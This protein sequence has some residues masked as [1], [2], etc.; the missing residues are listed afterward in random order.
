MSLGRERWLGLLLRVQPRSLRRA[1]GTEWMDTA[2]ARDAEAAA[3]GIRR[4]VA[5]RAREGAGALAAGVKGRLT[6]GRGAEESIKREGTMGT[7][8]LDLRYAVRS[9]RRAKG[10]T[11]V[12]VL[13]L[14][15]GIAAATTIFS[16]VHAVLLA[17]LPFAEPERLV[18]LWER[19]PDFGWDQQDAAPAN[20][21]DWRERVSA[22]DDVAAYR[23][24][25]VGRVTWLGGGEPRSVAFVDVT[26]NLFDVLGVRPVL[27]ALP[28]FDDT[29]A[30][31]EPWA[32]VSHAFWTEAL[33]GDPD[34]VGRTLEL[35]G[36]APRIRAVLPEGFRFPASEIDL[37]GPYGW[38]PDASDQ[39]WFRRA[40]FVTPVARLAP[41]ATVERA[42]AELDAV[43]LELQTEHP[44]LNRNMFAGLTPLRPWLAGDLAGPLRALMAAVTILL[45]LACVNVG[46]LFMARAAARSG[47]LSMRRAIGAG[48][49]RIV[50]Q[51]M[52]ESLLVAAGGGLIG[53]ALSAG[54]IR[55]LERIRPLG[56]AGTTSIELNTAVL[57]FALL[58][59]LVAA[60]T[61]G[62]VPAFRAARGADP[63]HLSG[64]RGQAGS[65]AS[66]LHRPGSLLIPAQTALAVI[67]LLGAGLVTRSFTRTLAEEPGM[68]P[69]GVWTFTL[70]APGNRYENRD[71]MLSFWDRVVTSLEAAPEVTRAAVTGGVPLTR[72]GWTSQLVVRDWEP[73]RLA[74]EVRHR[75]ATPGYF[76]V[77]GVPLLAG[78]GF[79]SDD[80]LEGERVAIVN[81]RFVDTYLAG[82]EAIGRQVTFDRE[83]TENSVWRTIV[84]VVGDERQLTLTQPP[85]PEVWEPMPQDWG[86]TR[87]VVVKLG[88]APSDP[89][90]IFEEAVHRVDQRIPLIGLRTMHDVVDD[91]SADARFLLLLFGLFAGLALL[92]A[93]VGVFGVTAQ[94]VRRRIP[95][96]GVRIALGAGAR[97][98]QDMI[99]RRVLALAG[100]GILVGVAVSLAVSGA[101]EPLLHETS[102][103]DRVAF[104]V[105]PVILLLVALISG[106][107]PARRASRVDPVRSL[108]GGG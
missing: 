19:N 96:L 77:M 82:E 2:R 99:L 108:T 45:L 89:R 14:G 107:L 23:G 90:A 33:G 9:L 66:G 8:S 98:V 42:R 21:L 7:W 100:A 104:T 92:L 63:A 75:A 70:S 29:W 58:A 4:L 49:G 91:A 26:G 36:G 37:W 20:V 46:N 53:V 101:L 35:D 43:A 73:G 28:T 103:R 94:S 30:V 47:E 17:P 97:Q 18:G 59:S 11:M 56:L 67:L 6:R 65:G 60:V 74:F 86:N 1:F 13:V 52:A 12:S 50:G 85:E 80:G 25:S 32:V 15:I 22:F 105:A 61:F 64:H 76:E 88:G 106:W 31:G 57:G 102:A 41:G 34:A 10:F 79:H 83:A 24:N 78:R 40:H 68:D 16:G 81:Q 62:L 93:A 54:G 27:G 71:A 69:E 5:H 87:S 95:E 44:T 72:S 39:A 38:A 55:V 3:R 48:R 84:G 51:L